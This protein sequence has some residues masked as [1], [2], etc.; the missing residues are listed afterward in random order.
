M[1]LGYPVQTSSHYGRRYNL[2]YGEHQS[3]LCTVCNHL[4]SSGNFFEWPYLRLAIR[5]DGK[6]RGYFKLK[7]CSE[8][9]EMVT[10]EWRR[11]DA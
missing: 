10:N 11:D 8:I 7:A 4:V 2:K 3:V 1:V 6:F 5:R 9:Q